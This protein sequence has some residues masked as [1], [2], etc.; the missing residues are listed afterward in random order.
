[1]LSTAIVIFRETLE[2]AM[3]LGIVL[4]ATRGLQ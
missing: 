1:M 4:A 2:I 3:I